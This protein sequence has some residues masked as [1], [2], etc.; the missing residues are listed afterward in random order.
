MSVI[1]KKEDNEEI[2]NKFT[3]IEEL[4]AITSK[5]Y[6][7]FSRI[8]FNLRIVEKVDDPVLKTFA[9]DDYM[10]FYYN[11]KMLETESQS[12][13]IGMLLHEVHHI[14]LKHFE[15]FNQPEHLLNPEL[16][17]VA[18]DL[19]INSLLT[20]Q[21]INMPKWACFPS[22]F[23]HKKN[24]KPF[25]ED[26]T[27]ETYYEWLREDATKVTINMNGPGCGSCGSVTGGNKHS[28]EDSSPEDENGNPNVVSKKMQ[29]YIV[30]STAED[31]IRESSRDRGS[32]P[33]YL[34][35]WAKRYLKPKV[36]WRRHLRSALMNCYNSVK[37]GMVDYTFSKPNRRS[38][39]LDDMG[40]VLPGFYSPTPRIGV[41]IDTSGSVSDSS[42]NQAISEVNAIMTKLGIE[43]TVAIVD[44]YLH[45]FETVKHINQVKLKGRG[46]TNMCI[47][48]DAFAKNKPWPNIIVCMTDG[49]TPWPE[50]KLPGTTN[51][52][53]MTT[54][55]YN[56]NVPVWAK[57]IEAF[58]EE[59]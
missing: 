10:R 1:K 47:G 34:E 16:R 8:L 51:L 46:G 17:N 25:E 14:I 42:L 22:N 21:H 26:Q 30:K 45:Q 28:S 48:Y 57:I 31:I 5:N 11:P 36:D 53:V 19:E 39:V 24:G 9:V 27:A 43:V 50:E 18:Q 37:T 6:R 40:I 54:R 56:K 59:E 23:K 44:A 55:H 32:V 49:D 13:L 20:K 58:P 15:R 2:L 52:I 3:P 12:N 41:I 38:S 4:F 35:Q 33:G 7:Y 29:E